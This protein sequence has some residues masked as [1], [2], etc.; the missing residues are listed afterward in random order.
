MRRAVEIIGKHHPQP[1]TSS[2]HQGIAFLFS[3]FGEL[4]SSSGDF[5]AVHDGHRLHSST[6]NPIGRFLS[7]S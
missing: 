4:R 1:T 6:P 7:D 2:L 5:Y 3:A